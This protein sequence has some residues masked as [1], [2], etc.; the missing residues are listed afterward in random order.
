MSSPLPALYGRNARLIYGTTLELEADTYS[1]QIDAPTVE[2]TNIS[3]YQSQVDWPIEQARL[4]PLIPT[5]I[6]L[7]GQKRRYMEFGTPGQVTYGG[8][9]RAK[10]SMTGI[11]TYQEST[12]HVGNYV[13]ILL[14]HS[15]AFGTFGVVTVPAIISQFTLDQSVRGYMKWSCSADSNGDFDITQV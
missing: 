11:C 10:I 7:A 15:A 4:T 1:L 8:M 12:P 13:R 5:M 2:T 6:S 9:R 3:I 14:T